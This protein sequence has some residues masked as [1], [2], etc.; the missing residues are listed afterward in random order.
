MAFP[1]DNCGYPNEDTRDSN[2]E[3]DI[4]GNRAGFS[5]QAEVEDELEEK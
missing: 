5:R 2:E 3:E 1:C 4:E